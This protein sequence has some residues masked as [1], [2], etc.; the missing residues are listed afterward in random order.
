M[1]TSREPGETRSDET[2]N[3]GSGQQGGAP[4]SEWIVA[5]VSG[6]LVLGMLGYLLAEGFR[7]PDGPAVVTVR[8]DSV[9]PV[10]DGYLLM[11]TLQNDGGDTAADVI[12]RGEL[13]EGGEIVEESEAT[14]DFVP[15]GAERG[16]ALHFE[17]D[18]AGRDLSVR[19][20]GFVPP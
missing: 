18:P 15:V 13:R 6:L 12:V 5:V 8:P 14:V 1:A 20:R 7:R 4:L 16:A 9:V 17:R 3:R 10:P 19:I 11:I 2:P